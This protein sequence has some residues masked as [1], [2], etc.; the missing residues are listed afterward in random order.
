MKDLLLFISI[1]FIIRINTLFF[2][3]HS[4]YKHIQRLIFIKICSKTEGYVRAGE[5]ENTY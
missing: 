5:L 1:A 2:Y 4:V 3:K